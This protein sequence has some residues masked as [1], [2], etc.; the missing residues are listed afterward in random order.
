M[1]ND[2]YER[3]Q[4]DRALWCVEQRLLH[5]YGKARWGYLHHD[6]NEWVRVEPDEDLV[7]Y[8]VPAI[9]LIVNHRKLLSA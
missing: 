9:D 6:G 3:K 7:R 8:Y 5:E 1:A 2:K 4:T